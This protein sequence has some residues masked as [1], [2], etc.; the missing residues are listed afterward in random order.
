MNNFTYLRS[1]ILIMAC[2]VLPFWTQAQCLAPTGLT[3]SPVTSNTAYISWNPVSGA[4]GYEY[5]VDQNPGTPLGFGVYTP[6]TYV[7]VNMLNAGNTYYCHVR[8]QCGS[9]TVS[10]WLIDSFVT[11]SAVCFMPTSVSAMA[12][13]N[14]SATISW[15]AM[16]GVP[17]Y[18]YLVSTSSA[19]PTGA[20]TSTTSTSAAISGLS[21]GNT[22][23]AFVRSVC[24]S[25]NQSG[26]M[27]ASFNTTGTNTCTTPTGLTAS[28]ITSSGANFNWNA[29]AG[30]IGYDYVI[31]FAPGPP[32]SAPTPVSTNSLTLNSLASGT[33]FYIHVRTRCSATSTS[34]WTDLQ[35]TTLS[36]GPCNAPTG[37]SFS[38][39]TSGSATISWSPASG[40]A[41]YEWIIDASVSSPAGSGTP[42][43]QTNASQTG[44]LANTTYY[45]HVRSS[46][47]STYSPWVTSSFVTTSIPPCSAP[48]N[49]TIS[50]ISS[51]GATITWNAVP[52][53]VSYEY[54]VDN[55]AAA[56]VT[57]GTTA[58]STSVTISTLNPST[59]YYAHV[60]SN[61][62]TG[63]STWATVPFTTTSGTPCPVP[64]GLNISGITANSMTLSWNSASGV[65]SYQYKVD[66]SPSSPA[67]AGISVAT[68]TTTINALLPATMYYAHVRSVCGTAFSAW[69]NSA[70]FITSATGISEASGNGFSIFPNPV[71]NE[72][73]IQTTSPDGII[74]IIDLSGRIQ[75]QQKVTAKSTTINMSGFA[76]GT[77]LVRYISADNTISV[78]LIKE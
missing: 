63:Y 59:A 64:T 10:P 70:S 54:K 71:K 17:G 43:T 60:R 22:Y 74:Q 15:P 53:A 67:G 31:D 56:P 65:S 50:G 78:P 8:T 40:V 34:G 2:A 3:I 47:G 42:T 72:L 29:V 66:N 20:G 69:A 68:N 62:G 18:E 58:T 51:T 7:S 48:A 52:G 21:P 1:G 45:G 26:W 12:I 13:T 35:F 6:N 76:S 57:A 44:L 30:A 5:L 23:Y 28:G 36:G 39:I 73:T 77:Y 49:L 75:L 38:N 46:C 25:T 55:S 24:S 27:Y 19:L 33:S 9:S 14:N 11:Q 32:L 61:C 37:I 16:S 41:G 4:T